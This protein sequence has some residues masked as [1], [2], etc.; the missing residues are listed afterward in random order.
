M[1]MNI[2]AKRGGPKVEGI[3]QLENSWWMKFIQF[4]L[5]GVEEL[6]E[7]VAFVA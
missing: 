2:I 3:L 7:I 5:F 4:L 1:T 6:G